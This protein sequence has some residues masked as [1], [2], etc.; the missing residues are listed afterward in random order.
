MVNED[1]L[2]KNSFNLTLESLYKSKIYKYLCKFINT[3]LI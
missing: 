3:L 2:D 1:V